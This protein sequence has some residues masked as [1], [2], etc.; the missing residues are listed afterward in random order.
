M[1]A[2]NAEVSQPFGDDEY[3]FRLGISEIEK[4]QESRDAGPLRIYRN[5]VSGDWFTQDIREVI[6]LGL[7]GGG[8]TDREAV[9][10]VK[11]TVDERPLM[12]HVELAIAVLGV[13]LFGPEEEEPGKPK[14]EAKTP[15]RS[16][17]K[18]SALP[19]STATGR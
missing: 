5:L 12:H 3:T 15:T 16:R 17:A 4:L 18:K 10:L 9:P 19:E 2:R 11:S 6:R 7:I 8:L 14:A 13:A 1:S